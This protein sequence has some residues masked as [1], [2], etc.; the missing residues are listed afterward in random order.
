MRLLILSHPPDTPSTR[1]RILPFLPLL[2]R[3]GFEVERLDI[4]SSLLDR[5]KILRR[6][7]EFD[8]VLHQKRLLPS[9]QF[10]ALRRRAK[11]LIYDFDDPM[12]FSRRGGRVTFSGSRASRFR[13]ALTQSDAVV[14]HLG[15]EALAREYGATNIHTIPTSVELD[16]WPMKSSWSSPRPTL[17]WLGTGA[18]LSNLR[19]IAGALRGHRLRI[20]ADH[21]LDLPGVEVEFVPWDPATEAG[22]VRSF[23]IALAPLS[24][25]PWSRTKMPFKILHYFASGVPVV[26]SALGAVRDVIRDGENGFLAGDWREKIKQLSDPELRERLGRGGRKTVEASFTIEGAYAKLKG[27]LETFARR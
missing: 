23:D 13:S 20:V 11:A 7:G 24:D 22:Q 27:I 4:P 10:R 21:T 16:R 12:V 17:G 5:W 1:H 25:D 14:C 15:S 9:W 19:E 3:D 26:A 18:N 6:A 8:V 2:E